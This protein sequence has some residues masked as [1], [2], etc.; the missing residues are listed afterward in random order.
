M[1]TVTTGNETHRIQGRIEALIMHL[2]QNSTDLNSH[3]KLRLEYNC[4]GPVIR[5]KLE[6]SLGEIKVKT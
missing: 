2:I 5:S 4:A 3:D 1:M 6:V